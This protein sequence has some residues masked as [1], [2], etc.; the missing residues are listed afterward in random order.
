MSTTITSPKRGRV[1]KGEKKEKR[2]DEGEKKKRIKPVG[3]RKIEREEAAQN[4]DGLN[5]STK[6]AHQMPRL[7]NKKTARTN[8]W[9]T[10]S[11]AN[12]WKVPRVAP[13]RGL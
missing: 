11:P 6:R 13:R 1:A 12:S 5:F 9:C 8:S 4:R 2:G 7:L 3:K 10:D